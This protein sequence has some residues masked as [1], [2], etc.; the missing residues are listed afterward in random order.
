MGR[1]ADAIGNRPAFMMSYAATTTSLGWL[2]ITKDLW[3]LYLFAVIFGF[4]WGAQ[5]VLRF[6]VTAEAFGLVSLGLIMGLFIWVA[7][8]IGLASIST[9]PY[10]LLIGWAA[11]QAMELGLAGAIIGIGFE[12]RS[13]KKLGLW[14]IVIFFV[15]AILGVVIQNLFKQ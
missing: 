14:C 11:G 3:G 4:G 6:S 5:A 9:A 15:C 7:L 12:R 13:L 1:V 2:L 8:S 10:F